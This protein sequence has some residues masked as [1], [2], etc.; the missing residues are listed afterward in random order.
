MPNTYTLIEAQT[1]S[2]NQAS[3]TL[4]SGGT[5]PQTY[6]D[7]FVRLSVRTTNTQYGETIRIKPNNSTANGVAVILRGYGDGQSSYTYSNVLAANNSLGDG[8][9]SNIF[10]CIDVYIPNYRGSNY[11]SFLSDGASENN[12][13][14]G[15]NEIV[16]S[17]WSNTAAITSLVFDNDSG[18]PFSLKSNSTFYLYG[19]KN[20]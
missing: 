12:A 5:I 1:L 13:T 7:L 9:T 8:A 4:G 10:A 17:L 16:G 19:I 3:V 15:R 18:S 11:K 14:N 2:S 6:T 20:S